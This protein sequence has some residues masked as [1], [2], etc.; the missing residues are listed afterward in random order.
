MAQ[1][2][3]QLLPSLFD[4]LTDHAPRKQKETQ[5]DKTIN[6][7]QYRRAVLRDILFLLNY[8]C[9][10]HYTIHYQP[11]PHQTTWESV[12]HQILWWS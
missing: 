6:I 1:F 5:Q 8:S 4:R 3:D 9:L 2:K 11:T 12:E 7:E 10:N